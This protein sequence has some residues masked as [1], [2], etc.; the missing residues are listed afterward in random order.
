MKYCTKCVMPDTRPGITFNEEGICS[1]CQAYEN[2]KTINYEKRFEELKE[3]CDKYRGMNG[4]DGF[5]CMIAVSGGKDSHF[6][7]Y[8]MKEVLGMNPLLV[9]VE[10]NFP[11]T[12]AGI[13][14][15]HNISEAFGCDIISMKPNI[16]AQKIVM[17]YTFE[18]YAKPTYFVDRFIYT[19]PLIMALKF[20]T[21]LLVYGENISYEYGGNQLKETFSAKDQ[22]LN[23]VASG[24]E[25]D[26]LIELEGLKRSD[27]NFFNAPSLEDINKLEPV[28][29]SYFLEWNSV[30]NYKFSSKVGFHDLRN[31]WKRTHHIE[32]FDQVDS[33]AYLVHPWLKYPKFGH[34]SATDYA[35]RMI[36]YGML[37]R[38]EGIELVKKH[39]HDLDSLCVRDF[40]N[41]LGYTEKEFWKIVDTFY[42]Q[43]LFKKVGYNWELKEPIYKK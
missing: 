7:T 39:D 35:A 15:L 25:I 34:A 16:K 40:C 28:Y 19:Y 36:R 5:D 32:D 8:I 23:G 2:R 29:L 6:Q 33:R 27:F 30:D 1:A 21:P 4:P 11:L 38:E 26:E 37:K 12:D 17:K 22:V 3:L 10:D 41:F 14:N 18:K 43:E 9:T 42:N 31:E 20:N 13:H 24:I